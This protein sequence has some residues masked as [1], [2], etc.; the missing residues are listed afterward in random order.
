MSTLG[1]L[2][3]CVVGRSVSCACVFITFV[4]AL[5]DKAISAT[6]FLVNMRPECEAYGPLGAQLRW[7]ESHL[8]WWSN[9]QYTKRLKAGCGSF[10]RILLTTFTAASAWPLGYLGLLVMKLKPS[11]RT[12]FMYSWELNWSPLFHLI[13]SGMPCHPKISFIY[14]WC[15]PP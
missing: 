14:L 9:I 7:S 6:M 5:L 3:F 12:K 8:Q 10:W 13:T 11:S 1:A 4:Y 15:M 2:E